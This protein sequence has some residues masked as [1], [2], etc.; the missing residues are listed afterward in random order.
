MFC[1]KIL[2]N[3]NGKATVGHTPCSKQLG[4][5]GGCES[6]VVFRRDLKPRRQRHIFLTTVRSCAGLGWT[7]PSLITCLWPNT[8]A[9]LS[10]FF[11]ILSDLKCYRSAFSSSTNHLSNAKHKDQPKKSRKENKLVEIAKH[12]FFLIF[13]L[14]LLNF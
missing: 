6:P 4:E 12:V 2:F 10:Q 5:G 9:D 1:L 7:G 14:W 11:S 3:V 8:L 13:N